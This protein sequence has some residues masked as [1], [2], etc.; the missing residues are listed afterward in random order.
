M[1][2][3]GQLTEWRCLSCGGPAVI[4]A[5]SAHC[6]AEHIDRLHPPSPDGTAYSRT[7]ASV[8]SLGWQAKAA[9]N[10]VLWLP[11]LWCAVTFVTPLALF[12]GVPWFF[13]AVVLT[14][15]LWRS[16]RVY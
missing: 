8:M 9:L 13:T 14:R 15:E 12:F 10:I 3:R 2:T 16:R 5:Q 7:A 1:S 4:C 6:V 11:V